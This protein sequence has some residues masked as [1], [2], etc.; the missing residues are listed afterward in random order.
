MAKAVARCKCKT[1]GSEF[2]AT[3]ICYNR[4]DADSWEEWASSNFDECSDCYK[5]RKQKERDAANAASAEENKSMGWAVLTGS[6]KQIAWAETIRAKARTNIRMQIK[7]IEACK[8]VLNWLSGKE[9]ASW[10]ID[11]R[12]C[13]SIYSGTFQK[14][15]SEAIGEELKALKA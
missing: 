15:V 2:T 4:R 6:P 11:N 12:D 5:A 7:N 8:V 14:M 1:C 10:W 9:K 13:F 3:K